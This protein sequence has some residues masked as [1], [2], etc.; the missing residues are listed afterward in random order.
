[1]LL[2]GDPS[3]HRD[4]ATFV[5]P[6]P[7][8]ARALAR[9][10]VRTPVGSALDVGAGSGVQALL[11]ARHSTRVTAT[12]VNPRA[13]AY[14]RLN[15]M[16]NDIHNVTPALGSGFQTLGRRRFFLIV[17]NPPYVVSPDALLMYRDSGLPGDTFCRSLVEA[18]ADHLE[19]GGLAHITCNWIV[20]HGE[21][22]DAPLRSWVKGKG[23]DALCILW[24]LWDPL[25]Y[26]ASWSQD[27]L[28]LGGGGLGDTL[29]R[30]TDYYSPL[31]LSAIGDGAIVLRRRKSGVNWFQQFE[32]DHEPLVSG[33]DHVR[34]LIE[35]QDHWSRIGG[36]TGIL[37]RTFRWVDG[38][39]LEQAVIRRNGRYLAD[40]TVIRD[41]A[42]LPLTCSVTP[43]ATRV[44]LELDGTRPVRDIV[45]EVGTILLSER[46][47][48]SAQSAQA[49]EKLILGGFVVPAD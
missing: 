33:G 36:S 42:G 40:H 6:A 22:W 34:R 23:C 5:A 49:I 47:S 43:A 46:D 45:L 48:L 4:A 13:L 20:P 38:H 7:Q 2:L 25:L 41:R 11:A 16:L 39:R 1:M 9:L 15:A 8:T 27:A 19:D 17:S 18:A 32:M 37:D 12:D 35:G 3:H 28:V 29:D 26:A 31:G 24:R 14:C 10:T 44:L 30:W 21:L